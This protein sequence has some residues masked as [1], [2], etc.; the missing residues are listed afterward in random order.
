MKPIVTNIIPPS[1]LNNAI[2]RV[3]FDAENAI[4]RTAY[5]E[6]LLTKKWTIQFNLEAPAATVF[7]TV[8]FKLA[9][10]ACRHELEVLKSLLE[11]A[12]IPN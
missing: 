5:A 11:T 1:I 3:D 6:F 2:T 8:M 12:E 4:H 7:G 9:E 10:Y